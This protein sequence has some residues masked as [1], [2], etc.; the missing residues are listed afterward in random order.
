MSTWN[1]RVLA[2]QDAHDEI[3]FEINRVYYED[4]KTD[5]HSS[6]S[7]PIGETLEELKEELRLMSLALDKPILWGDDRFPLEYENG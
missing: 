5:C 3:F 2:C 6:T 7:T 4:G 1:Y